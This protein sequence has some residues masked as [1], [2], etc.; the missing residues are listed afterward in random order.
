MMTTNFARLREGL[1]VREALEQI[2]KQAEGL[3]TI[4]YIYVVDD[5]EHLRGTVSARRLLFGHGQAESR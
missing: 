2:G 3:E 5:E 4:Y 1:T